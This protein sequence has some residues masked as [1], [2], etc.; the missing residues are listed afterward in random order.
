MRGAD[1]IE[2]RLE[3]VSEDCRVK[4][5]YEFMELGQDRVGV[6]RCSAT[7]H[8]CVEFVDER[9]QLRDVLQLQF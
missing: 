4:C 9:R 7:L 5:Q 2:V 8:V 6:G 1:A 3:G